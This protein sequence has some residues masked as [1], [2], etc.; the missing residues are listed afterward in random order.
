MSPPSASSNA[1]ICV[2][3]GRSANAINFHKTC[4]KDPKALFDVLMGPKH[5]HKLEGVGLIKHHLGG[6]FG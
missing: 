5:D 1:F 3:L 4:L 6:G 2:A